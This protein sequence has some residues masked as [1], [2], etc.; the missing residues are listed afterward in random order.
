MISEIS[1]RS[2]IEP[3][4]RGQSLVEM[5]MWLT[6]I[7][8][9]VGGMVDV[10]LFGLQVVKVNAGARAG[11][12]LAVDLDPTVSDGLGCTATQDF[13]T[14]IECITDD[15]LKREGVSLGGS[16]DDIVISVVTL[17][18]GAVTARS[19]ESYMGNQATRMTDGELSSRAAG[20]PDSGMVVVEV[21]HN[22][23]PFLGLRFIQGLLTPI[24]NGLP[25]Y[26]MAT[27]PLPDA[28]P[29]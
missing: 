25:A 4:S 12:R 7:I 14:L 21:F 26:A 6:V 16:Q 1:R 2:D 3:A 13:Y 8:F 29:S 10:V 28:A 22:Y 24:Q 27:M 20:G 17:Q 23:V 11:A 19:T 18:G 5:A 9:L 15:T